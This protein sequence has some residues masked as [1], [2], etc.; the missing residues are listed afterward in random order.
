[1]FSVSTSDPDE[2]L[3]RLSS[4]LADDEEVSVVDAAPPLVHPDLVRGV[5]ALTA[6]FDWSSKEVRALTFLL[7]E[8]GA[9]SRD[10]TAWLA[11]FTGSGA[12]RHPSDPEAELS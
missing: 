7:W 9:L 10:E 8:V 4:M 5:R 12:P 6:A 11:G 2:A 3:S 1:M